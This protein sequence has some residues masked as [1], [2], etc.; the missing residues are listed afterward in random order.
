MA[1]RQYIAAMTIAALWLAEATL[2]V[3]AQSS[4]HS[5]SGQSGWRPRIEVNPGPRLLYRRC[6]SWYEI[7]YRPSGTVLYPAMHCWWVRG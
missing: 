6:T 4:S 5:S 3:A 2:T 7:Q 1:L